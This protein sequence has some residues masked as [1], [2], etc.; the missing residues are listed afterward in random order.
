ME[1]RDMIRMANQIADF[2]KGY[3]HDSATTEM[4]DHINRFWEPRMRASLLSYLEHGGE[5][6]HPLVKDS[7]HLYRRPK[8]FHPYELDTKPGPT[9]STPR[10]LAKAAAGYAPAEDH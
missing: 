10:D 6:L 8:E 7:A 9:D 2:F 5:G 4:A 3:D 1:S